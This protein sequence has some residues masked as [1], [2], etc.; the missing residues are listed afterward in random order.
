MNFNRS[1]RKLIVH[2][3]T[4]AIL[5][6]CLALAWQLYSIAY[7]PLFRDV[8]TVITADDYTIPQAKLEVV[9]DQLEKKTTVTVDVSQLRNPFVRE[10]TQP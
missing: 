6:S 1:I 9:L 7:V 8:T 3:C 2:I 5:S 4:V 10:T